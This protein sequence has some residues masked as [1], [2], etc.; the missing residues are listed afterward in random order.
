[1]HLVWFFCLFNHRQLKALLLMLIFF[2]IFAP[3]PYLL[4]IIANCFTVR[5]S[6]TFLSIARLYFRTWPSINILGNQT[7]F[8]H[9]KLLI[10]LPTFANILI[11]NSLWCRVIINNVLLWKHTFIFIQHQ[12]YLFLFPMNVWHY[13]IQCLCFFIRFKEFMIVF[14]LR[15]LLCI[16]IKVSSRIIYIHAEKWLYIIL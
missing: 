9:V 14:F 2:V 16:K 3:F 7:S 8:I 6:P 11:Y 13:R 1:M 15:F 12:H 5:V 4:T 10:P